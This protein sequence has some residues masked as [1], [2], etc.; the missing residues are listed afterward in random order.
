MANKLSDLKEV[1]KE[2]SSADEGTVTPILKVGADTTTSSAMGGNGPSSRSSSSLQP[3]RIREGQAVLETINNKCNQAEEDPSHAALQYE[4][5]TFLLD[6]QLNFNR[7]RARLTL[8]WS[9]SS[10]LGRNR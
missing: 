3:S 4:T 8:A 2:E 7:A 5:F 1:K 10:P 6:F 9:A